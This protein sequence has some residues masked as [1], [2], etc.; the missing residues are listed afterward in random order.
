MRTCPPPR[1]THINK[2]QLHEAVEASPLSRQKYH[3]PR[4]QQDDLQQ[5]TGEDDGQG[6]AQGAERGGQ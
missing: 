4:P 3:P 5:D 1:S 2:R 6:G